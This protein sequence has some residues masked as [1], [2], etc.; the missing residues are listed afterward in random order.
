VI[1]E[2]GV[3][4]RDTRAVQNPS[5]SQSAHHDN[6]KFVAIRH[7][8]HTYSMFRHNHQTTFDSHRE[9]IRVEYLHHQQ[10]PYHHIRCVSSIIQSTMQGIPMEAAQGLVLWHGLYG[11]RCCYGEGLLSLRKPGRFIRM[12]SLRSCTVVR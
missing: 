10:T 5:F 11:S 12:A 7:N 9:E 2:D 3:E 1:T 6:F 4:A 8:K